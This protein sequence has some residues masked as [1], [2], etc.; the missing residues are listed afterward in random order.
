VIDDFGSLGPGFDDGQVLHAAAGA[1]IG[2]ALSLGIAVYMRLGSDEAE[3]T[4]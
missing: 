1:L 4:I 3:N 2:S